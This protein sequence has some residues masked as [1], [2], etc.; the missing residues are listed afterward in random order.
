MGP[1]PHPRLTSR[2][3]RGRQP[4][5]DCGLPSR[6]AIRRGGS[7]GTGDEAGCD[8]NYPPEIHSNLIISAQQWR[9]DST[10][11]SFTPPPPRRPRLSSDLVMFIF[12]EPTPHRSASTS[13]TSTSTS[14][15]T[16]SSS[17]DKP[18]G[19]TR[20]PKPLSAIFSHV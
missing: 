13:P 5:H 10:P 11:L 1:I 20:N 17:S 16:M 9:E 15:P 4:I 19:E 18:S 3:D 14:I 2:P 12:S 8:L 6:C 7:R